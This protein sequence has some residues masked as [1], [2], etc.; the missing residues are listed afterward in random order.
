MRST[1]ALALLALAASVC[2]ATGSWASSNP[3]KRAMQM[4]RELRFIDGMVRIELQGLIVRRSTAARQFWRVVGVLTVTPLMC[5]AAGVRALSASD[6][7]R[8][9]ATGRGRIR[10]S[11]AACKGCAAWPKRPAAGFA[12]EKSRATAANSFVLD[13]FTNEGRRIVSMIVGFNNKTTSILIEYR[14]QHK[15]VEILH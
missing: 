5:T 12:A 11:E 14:F 13:P 6:A 15:A 1:R 10:C 9:A 7:L 3:A 4:T 8:I 2:A